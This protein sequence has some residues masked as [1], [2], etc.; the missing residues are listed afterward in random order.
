[1]ATRPQSE[2]GSLNGDWGF[3]ATRPARLAAERDARRASAERRDR[4]RAADEERPVNVPK[5]LA[6]EREA[7]REA[8]RAARAAGGPERPRR[9][10]PPREPAARV[11][12]A[13]EPVLPSELTLPM[14]DV[15]DADATAVSAPPRPAPR[16]PREPRRTASPDS[17]RVARRPAPPREPPRRPP[18]PR[19]PRAPR[20]PSEALE[21]RSGRPTA[22]GI[23]RRQ[24][25]LLPLIALIALIAGGVGAYA[26][27]HEPRTGTLQSEVTTLQGQLN[28]A[29]QQLTKLQHAEA[30]LPS[31]KAMKRLTKTVNGLKHSVGGLQNGSVAQQA[32]L[33]AL[34]VCLP[35]VA[36]DLSGTTVVTHGKHSVTTSPGLS[37]G[38]SALLGGG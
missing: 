2:T 12:V 4:P 13:A 7:E 19:R 10:R 34:N 37:A 3:D 27:T 17:E 33:K 25:I 11:E 30:Q 23:S 32:E 16:E 9:P 26:L 28:G 18:A 14:P 8:Q 15:L 1:M 31:A 20:R 22:G 6:A 21:F 29:R 5:R 38:C 35:Q 24:Q 36:Q